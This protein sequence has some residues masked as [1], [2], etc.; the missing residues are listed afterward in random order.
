MLKPDQIS[1]IPHKPGCYLYFNSVKKIIYVGKAKDL[2]KRV[3]QYFQKDHDDVKTQE[4]VKHIVEIDYV[5]TD[6]E[7]EALLLESRLIK[8]YKPKYNVDLKHNE[9]YA[10]IKITNEELPRVITARKKDN[11]GEFFG[12]FVDG[13]SRVLTVKTVNEAFQLRTCKTLPK[14]V[15]LNYHLGLCSGP[16][17]NKVSK[18]E[19][20]GQVAQARKYLKGNVSELTSELKDEM[21]QYAKN[22]QFELAKTKRDQINAIETLHNRQK[23][24]TTKE[25]DQDVIGVSYNAEKVVYFVFN[26]VKGIISQKDEYELPVVSAIEQMNREF[27]MQ[28]YDGKDAPKEIIVRDDFLASEDLALVSSALSQNSSF[29]IQLVIPKQGEKKQLLTLACTNADYALAGENPTLIKLKELLKLPTV[30]YEIECYDISNL[31]DDYIVGARI[32][33]SHGK[34]NKEMY[35]KYRIKWQT[36]QNDFAAMYEVLKRRLYPISIGEEKAPDLLVIDGGRGQ[37]NAALDAMKEYRLKIP[38]IS[39][40]KK[41]EEIYFP[42]L[43]KP[44]KTDKNASRDPAI[45]LLQQIRDETHR[46]VITYHRSLRDTIKE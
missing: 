3:T 16:C 41:E 20:L 31:R 18:T 4:L 8:Q 25:F 6:S 36:Q 2:K 27:I 9:R 5:I 35:R 1:Q 14:T 32:H 30:P 38:M 17:E 29:A 12:P 43:L 46:F 15:C 7:T 26:I 23:V 40:A 44:L 11:S 42:G 24:D 21:K 22:Q 19:Y 33:F 28:Y 37:L 10:Y 39:L 13:Y 45:R 34:P